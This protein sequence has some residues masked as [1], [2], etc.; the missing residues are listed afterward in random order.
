MS[1]HSARSA[2]PVSDAPGRSLGW[3]GATLGLIAIL[4]LVVAAHVGAVYLRAAS[5]SWP[6]L[7]GDPPG[8]VV[9]LAAAGLLVVAAALVSVGDLHA[10]R[11]RSTSRLLLP[12]AAVLAAT[13]GALRGSV[14][15]FSDHPVTEHAF[16]SVRWL[17]GALDTTLAWTLTL[18]L[19][20]AAVHTWRGVIRPGYH[21][22]L[23]VASLWAWVT[24]AFALGSWLVFAGAT[25]WW[26]GV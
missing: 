8:L 10:R 5:P 12:L 2:R 26:G 20:V 25:I 16:W 24:A 21:A 23:A 4:H 22:E 17:L 13:A 6:P 14:T 18:V 7:A 1:L 3:W 9:S 11:D 19:V 15:I